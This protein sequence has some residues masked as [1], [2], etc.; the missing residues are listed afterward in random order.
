MYL[1]EIVT[2]NRL[3]Q[4]CM[5]KNN[6]QIVTF[7]DRMMWTALATSSG[8]KIIS[9]FLLKT[10]ELWYNMSDSLLEGWDK[11]VN[12][13][14]TWTLGQRMFSIFLKKKKSYK[15]QPHCGV[16]GKL[17]LSLITFYVI[18]KFLADPSSSSCYISAWT[19]VVV[20][21]PPPPL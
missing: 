3:I 20:R 15:F 8:L 19:N 13:W 11:G 7:A 5:C 12:V 2:L 17:R 9:Y 16:Q 18:I 1:I 21:Q 6:L 10:A 14:T 4:A